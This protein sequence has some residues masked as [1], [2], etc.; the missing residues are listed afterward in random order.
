MPA[1]KK[2]KLNEAIKDCHKEYND[3]VIQSENFEVDHRFKYEKREMLFDKTVDELR[4]A[5]IDFV[6][7]GA[8]PLCE[9]LDLHDVENFVSYVTY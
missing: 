9:Y 6:N 5:L 4:E 8:Y 1:G 2:N 7:K 3:N